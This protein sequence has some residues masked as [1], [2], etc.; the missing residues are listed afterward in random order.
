MEK[1]RL[2]I[3][4]I[5]DYVEE[6]QQ[7]DDTLGDQCDIQANDITKHKGEER[8]EGDVEAEGESLV[9]A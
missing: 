7:D 6:L 9:D 2:F 1:S 8:N 3:I 5:Q 4:T